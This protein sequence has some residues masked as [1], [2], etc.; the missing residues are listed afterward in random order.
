[1]ALKRHR[2]YGT[3]AV[4]AFLLI[5]IILVPLTAAELVP[6]GIYIGLLAFCLF[7]WITR[8]RHSFGYLCDECIASMPLVP[9]KRADELKPALWAMHLL[10]G[11]RYRALALSLCVLALSVV[12]AV[13][14]FT[15]HTVPYVIVQEL[16][17]LY[18]LVDVISQHV[19]G[20]YRPWCPYCNGGGG[21]G[22]AR[23]ESPDPTI[24][25]P[26]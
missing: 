3:H 11:H 10:N 8:I 6:V 22:G 16:V 7:A 4:I 9:Q 19:H 25:Q 12:S 20:K 15:G 14:L 23:A 1:M 17:P 18:V 21:G 2:H 26:A 5:T 24:P 13:L